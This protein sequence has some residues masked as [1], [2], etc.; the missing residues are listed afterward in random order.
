VFNKPYSFSKYFFNEMRKQISAREAARFILYPRFVMMIINHKLPSL[1]MIGPFR[2]VTSIVRRGYDEFKNRNVGDPGAQDVAIFGAVLDINFATPT[3]EDI[4]GFIAHPIPIQ[5]VYPDV[6]EQEPVQA[7]E[8]QAS[9]VEES[10]ASKSSAD[11]K[12][13][14]V[15]VQGGEEEPVLKKRTVVRLNVGKSAADR[16]EETVAKRRSETRPET[17]AASES[18]AASVS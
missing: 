2:K 3:N 1:P 13:K 16:I 14:A 11:K 18:P 8:V 10:S 7:E 9:V 6:Q 17:T 15:N 12:R 4:V 5:I